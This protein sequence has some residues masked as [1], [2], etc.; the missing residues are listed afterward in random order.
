VPSFA[1]VLCNYICCVV[2]GKTV[3]RRGDAWFELCVSGSGEEQE[4]VYRLAEPAAMFPD[5]QQRRML[6]LTLH[7]EPEAT[8]TLPY[9]FLDFLSGVTD[10]MVPS[11]IVVVNDYGKATTAELRGLRTLKPTIYGYS[12]NH[13]VHFSVFDASGGREGVDPRGLAGPGRPQPAQGQQQ[14]DRRRVGD[15]GG[16]EEGGR[17]RARHGRDGRGALHRG[18]SVPVAKGVKSAADWGFDFLAGMAQ[19]SKSDSHGVSLDDMAD[20]F[21]SNPMGPQRVRA[22]HLDPRRADFAEELTASSPMAGAQHAL[23]TSKGKG[24]ASVASLKKSAAYAAKE[25]SPPEDIW[26]GLFS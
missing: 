25:A 24:A 15:D 22:Q 9:T 2:P 12:L 17:G 7:D 1:A 5:A 10:L 4:Y 11:G 14:D 21:S 26:N 13:D 18:P 8:F 16:G 23:A 20:V 19:D 3:Q 6:E